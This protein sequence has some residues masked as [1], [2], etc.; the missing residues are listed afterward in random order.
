MTQDHEQIVERSRAWQLLSIAF[1]HPVPELH[2]LLADRRFQQAFEEAL[3]MAHGVRIGLPSLSVDFQDFEAQ[4]I[5]LFDTG[6]KGRPLAPLRASA[7]D[8][9]L[10]GEPVPRLMLKY[11][12]FYKHFGVQARTGQ[13]DNALADHLTC[14][15]DCLAWLTHL[16]ARAGAQSDAEAGYRRA[17]G[18]FITRLLG[19]HCGEFVPRLSDACAEQGFDPVFAALGEALERLQTLELERFGSAGNL[20]V[21]RPPMGV[22]VA[23]PTQNLWR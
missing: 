1:A 15:L 9:L 19:P 2:G 4:Y 10:A 22:A 21:S 7:Y 11:A 6:S 3:A 8:V 14:Q 16:E 20:S 13:G 17:Q 23:G 12:Q 5:T 18:D